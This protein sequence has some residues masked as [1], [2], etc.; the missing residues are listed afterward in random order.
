[1]PWTTGRLLGRNSLAL[2]AHYAGSVGFCVACGLVF[3]QHRST[4]AT[5]QACA[6]QPRGV[7]GSAA[8]NISLMEP[9]QASLRCAVAPDRQTALEPELAEVRCSVKLGRSSGPLL[10]AQPDYRAVRP[11][12]LLGELG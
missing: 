6:T 11:A 5:L 7:N 10:T 12:Q 3:T 1:V 2:A 8:S 4:S 9:I